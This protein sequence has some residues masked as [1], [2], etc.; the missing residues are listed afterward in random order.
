MHALNAFYGRPKI[1]ATIFEEYQKEYDAFMRAKFNTDISVANYDY[2]N[3]DQNTIISYVLKYKDRWYTRYY[4]IGV[5]KPD[6]SEHEFIFVFNESHIWA[7]RCV[8]GT[9]YR[10]DSLSGVSPKP[11]SAAQSARVGVIVPVDL[12]RELLIVLG[13]LRQLTTMLQG[14]ECVEA[15]RTHLIQLHKESNILGDLEVPLSIAME[16]LE[17]GLSSGRPRPRVAALVKKY[18]DF[19]REFTQGRYLDIDLIN[20]NVPD[21]IC[22]F[23]RMARKL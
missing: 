19:L 3:S 21:I 4:A 9:W 13:Q 23:L 10:V 22:T 14:G 17:I 15:M 18:N 16:I 20:R 6:L 7:M 5:T 12:G 2:V 1:T 8:S 11:L